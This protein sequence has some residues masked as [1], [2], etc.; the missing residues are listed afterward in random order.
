L[1]TW[2]GDGL[3]G[4]CLSLAAPGPLLWE[5]AKLVEFE[6]FLDSCCGVVMVGMCLL[7]RFMSYGEEIGCLVV[8]GDFLICLLNN[9]ALARTEEV[10]LVLVAVIM[11]FSME[12]GFE[13]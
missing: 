13:S 4:S 5:E 1:N 11:E 9:L 2:I 8:L 6:R 12:E 3:R 7:G 10:I